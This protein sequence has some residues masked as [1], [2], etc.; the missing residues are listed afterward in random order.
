MTATYYAPTG[1]HPPQTQLLTDRAVF[2][3]A[4][5]V[6]PR[7]TMQDIV[8]SFL[9]F[10]EGT[11]LWVLARPMSGF[12]ETFSHYIMVVAPGGGSDR[13]ETDPTAQAVL[14][15]V[16]GEATL[17]LDGETHL[18]SPGGYAYLPAGSAWRLHNHGQVPLRF[19]WIRRPTK[20]WKDWKRRR[21]SSPTN[22]TS[23]R[24]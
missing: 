8:T 4:Y 11:R 15:V 9:P 22:R 21:P 3:P 23:P 10:W 20:R 14:F 24:A 1:G 19:H 2:T 18:L 12:S 16:E 13:P 5:A 17:D 7:G 6:L